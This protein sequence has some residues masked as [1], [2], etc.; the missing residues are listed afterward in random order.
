MIDCNYPHVRIK[1]HQTY[2]NILKL[3]PIHTLSFK[4]FMYIAQQILCK[5]S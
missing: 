3:I 2:T 5:S 1:A 4:E